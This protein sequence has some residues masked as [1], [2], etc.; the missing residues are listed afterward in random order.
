MRHCQEKGIVSLGTAARC[1]IL[2][3]LLL[4]DG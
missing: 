3:P 4:I 1:Y 2:C